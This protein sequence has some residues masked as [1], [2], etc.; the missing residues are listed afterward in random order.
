[1]NLYIQIVDGVP[2]NHPATEENLVS[3]LGAVPSNWEPFKRI[4]NPCFANKKLIL[5][6]PEPTYEKVDGVWQDVW[7]YREKTQE[8]IRAEF[9]PVNF[10]DNF[11]AWVFDEAT[12][13]MDPP[14]PR[15]D[16]GKVY[17]WCGAENNWKESPP[18][19]NDGK[20]YYFDFYNWV[21]VERPV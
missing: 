14:F 13:G 10:R 9:F 2:V 21:Y 5:V 1:M 12:W 4:E 16:D 11:D 8:D 20:K 18:H 7:H 15:P 17:R 3:A 19:P 6:A